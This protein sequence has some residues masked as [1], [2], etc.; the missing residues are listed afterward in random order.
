MESRLALEPSTLLP[1]AA[2]LLLDYRCDPHAD[3]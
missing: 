3:L 2:S 1:A